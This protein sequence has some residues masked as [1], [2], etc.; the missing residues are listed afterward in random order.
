MDFSPWAQPVDDGE[1]LLEKFGAKSEGPPGV[2]PS[3]L[4][5]SS[6][7]GDVG[8]GPTVNING[9]VLPAPQVAPLPQA[10]RPPLSRA[11]RIGDSI[12]RHIA[13]DT[14]QG[15][16]GIL[17]P[18]EIQGARPS[19]LQSLFPAAD[20]P[21]AASR[22]VRNLNALVERK[23]LSAQAQR[24]QQLVTDRARIARMIGPAP[25]DT[26]GFRKWAHK[27]YGLYASIGDTES[28]QRMNVVMQQ[29]IAG[30]NEAGKSKT[31]DNTEWVD[32]GGTKE[33]RY[34]DSGEQVIGN[35]GKPVVLQKTP[36]PRDPNQQNQAQQNARFTHEMQLSDDYNKDTRTFRELALK[37]DGAV[38]ELPR[39]LQG[40]G[41]A[42]T[43][44]LYAFVSA[45]DPNSAVREGE[46]G[47]VRSAASLRAQ[48]QQLLDKYEKSGESAVVPKQMLQQMGRLME[49]RLKLTNDYVDERAD[50]Y[51]ERGKRW[52]VDP[53]TFPR[54]HTRSKSNPNADLYKQFGVDPVRKP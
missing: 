3:T 5:V 1:S 30:E 35:D 39:A 47:L 48:A 45:M 44:I 28:L 9:S 24:Q 7:L 37:L 42:A 32:V 16:E 19:L 8:P 53:S 17:T 15:Y 20:E 21:H 18:E 12:V 4:P 31:T 13:G 26:A 33:L 11:G 41:A 52:D 38:E 10:P 54:L 51:T 25:S 6:L 22:W 40:D 50:Y 34:K 2:P 49:R 43:N 23:A 46:I 14:P 29:V 36:G 27:A